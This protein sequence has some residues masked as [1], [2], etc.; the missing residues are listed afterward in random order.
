MVEHLLSLV[1]WALVGIGVMGR[2]WCGSYISGNKNSKLM[3]EGPYSISRNPLYFFTFL[4]G[5]GVMLITETLLLPILAA[6]LYG[7]YYPR[8]MAREEEVLL[9]LHGTTFE[10]YRAS[11]PRFW[12]N[13]TLY[14]EPASYVISAAAFRKHLADV[15]WFVIAG[16]TV[17]F[18]E[19]MHVS[20]FLPTLLRL[21]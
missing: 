15:L 14:S 16:G 2:I 5:F 4:G 18:L 9:K 17:E 7:A 1:G 3:V 10:A 8:V 21:Y 20:G 6:V 19:G 13:W 11:V 12:P